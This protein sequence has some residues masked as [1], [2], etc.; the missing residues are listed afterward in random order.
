[1]GEENRWATI[2]VSFM[3]GTIFWR[4]DKTSTIEAETKGV[5]TLAFFPSKDFKC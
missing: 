1:M 4:E 3:I 2:S 5:Y